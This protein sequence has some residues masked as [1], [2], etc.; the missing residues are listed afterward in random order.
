MEY[1]LLLGFDFSFLLLIL[2]YLP[3]VLNMLKD[4]IFHSLSYSQI[5][6]GDISPDWTRGI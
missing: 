6:L 1:F 3:R 4:I 2:N 5:K